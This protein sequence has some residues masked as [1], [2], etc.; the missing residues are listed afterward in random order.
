M[1]NFDVEGARA[2]GYTD[3]EI[4]DYL[5]SQAAFDIAA[6]RAEG[7]TDKEIVQHLRPIRVSPTPE[8]VRPI[9]VEPDTSLAQNVGV[10]TSALSPY[11][12]AAGL[13]AAVGAP[14]AGVGAIPGAAGGVLSLG[15]SDLGTGIY[16]AAAPMFGGQRVP[17]PSETIRS[18]LEN[19]G[20]G[21]APQ[22]PGQ[23]VLLRTAEGAASAL[24]GASALGTLATRQAPGVARNIFSLLAQQRGAQTAAGAGAGALPTAAQQFAGVENPLALAGLSLAGG[25]AGGSM[26]PRRGTKVTADELSK[27]STDAYAAAEAAGVRVSGQ[28]MSDLETQIDDLLRTMEYKPSMHPL[29]AEVRKMFADEAGKEISFKGLEEFRKAARDRPYS[30]GGGKRGT[31]TERAMVGMMSDA[32]N[33]FMMNLK[34]TQTTAGPRTFTVGPVTVRRPY[35]KGADA[36]DAAFYLRNAREA[37]R[38]NFQADLVETTAQRALKKE[39]GTPAKNLREAF[40][41]IADNPSRMARLTPDTQA[42]IKGVSEGRGFKT[43]ERIGKRAPNLNIQNLGAL[44][45]GGGGFGASMAYLGQPVAGALGTGM[46]ATLGGGSI[47]ARTFANKLAKAQAN[48][49]ANIIRGGKPKPGRNQIA[50]QSA[51]Q[52]APQGQ[53]LLGFGISAGGEQYPIFGAAGTQ[54][55]EVNL[56]SID[57]PAGPF[58]ARVIYDPEDQPFRNF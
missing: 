26:V 46:L 56:P 43:L 1:E 18:G 4:A 50:A 20:V 52:A 41:K 57:N 45:G 55:P 34:P 21:R 37:A 33:D 12:T 30:D 17:L 54:L 51:L 7:Y 11:A 28:A 3:A 32:I 6:A 23:E 22:T 39:S 13:G 31:S 35:G 14:L 29:V 47:A 49:M 58:R 5:A 48:E 36:S 53:V 27:A 15:L 24:G 25:M 40:A 10:L 9:P 44:M 19:I 38:K 8:A 2:E 16:N 42:L